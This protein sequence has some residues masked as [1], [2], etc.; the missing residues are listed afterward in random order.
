MRRPLVLAL[1][2]ALAF[3]GPARAQYI[4]RAVGPVKDAATAI[5]VGIMQCFGPGYG[6]KIPPDWHA[7]LHG[8]MWDVWEG[9]TLAAGH[10]CPYSSFAVSTA[11]GKTN[12]TMCE[13]LTIPRGR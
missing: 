4:S 11:D 8:D 12:C 6:T 10:D 7:D 3:S 1:A 5:R 9:P 13:A 2:L